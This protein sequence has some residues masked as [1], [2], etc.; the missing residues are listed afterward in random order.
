MTEKYNISVSFRHYCCSCG[1]LL[2]SREEDVPV[3]KFDEMC[4][5][6]PDCE[7]TD[8]ME[9]KGLCTT[10]GLCA[11]CASEEGEGI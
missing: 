1:K 7:M 11:K 2:R 8:Y 10:E 9:D 3:D 6:N 4:K 5:S